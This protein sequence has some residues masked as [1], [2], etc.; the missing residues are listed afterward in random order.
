M[1][2]LFILLAM[3]LT[4]VLLTGCGIRNAVYDNAEAYRIGNAEITEKVA[5]ISLEWTAGTIGVAYHDKDTVLITEKSTSALTE[6]ESVHWYLDG[7]TLRI[8]F[9]ASG[10]SESLKLTP[11]KKDLTLTLPKSFWADRIEIFTASADFKGSLNAG[12]IEI[13]SSSG[14]VWLDSDAVGKL[15]LSSSSGA[16][17]CEAGSVGEASLESHSGR[18]LASIGNAGRLDAETSSGRIE[19][20][21]DTLGEGEVES[22][23]GKV[24]FTV[25]KSFG[26]VKVSAFSGDVQ[27]FL[28]EEVGYT[29]TISTLSGDI[30]NAF[31]VVSEGKMMT[32]ADGKAVLKIETSSGNIELE[33]NR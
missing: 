10:L 16:I 8:H 18:L 27:L 32:Y 23:S 31:P 15:E 3:L 26:E 22:N 14:T 25:K 33:K 6:E 17:R 4:V 12:E 28:P 1:K 13:A 11:T 21:V 19:V 9:A 2:K 30:R 20:S 24:G 29:A 5:N 7:A